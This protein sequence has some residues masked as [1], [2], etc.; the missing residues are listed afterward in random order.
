MVSSMLA[1]YQQQ[2][3][4]PVWHLMGNE[5]N[6]MPGYSGVQVVADAYLKGFKGFDTAL[7]FKAV[8]ATA[9]QDTRGLN[10][11]KK[12]GYIPADSMVESV[13]MGMEYSIADASI[14]QMAKKM[15]KKDDYQ[16]FFK[17]GMNYRNYFNKETGFMR[18]RIG[19]KA[20]RT[21]FSPFEARHMKDDFA[22][23]NSWQYTWMVPQD[24]E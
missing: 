14:A 8:K 6:T 19:N 22:E 2:G 15:G 12:Y 7:A 9:M 13:A 4:L 18:G 1:I 21:P 23:G 16:Y 20:W 3:S 11:V 5:T 17:R 10:Y 24:V